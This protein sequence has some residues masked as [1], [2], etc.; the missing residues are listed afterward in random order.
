MKLSTLKKPSSIIIT[1]LLLALIFVIVKPTL[2][3]GII[4]EKMAEMID[5]K[6]LPMKL[7][8]VIRFELGG[9]GGGIYNLVVNK[10]KAIVTE[11]DTDQIDLLFCM[12]A[13]DFNEL[14]FSM[15]GGNASESVFI[16]LIM[17]SKLRTA[18]DIALLQKVLAPADGT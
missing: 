8:V 2:P 13:A 17:S 16:S 1:L 10:D 5:V 3:S 6:K 11:G 12:S 18:G 14:M 7:P 15:A 4:I 9:K